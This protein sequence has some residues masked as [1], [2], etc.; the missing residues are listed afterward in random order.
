MK[1][2]IGYTIAALLAV[3]ILLGGC[4]KDGFKK[5]SANDSTLTVS[6]LTTGLYDYIAAD[7]SGNVYA[8]HLNYG[9]D[10]IYKFDA[11]G[12]KTLFYTAPT[13][14]DHDT[15]VKHTMACLSTDSL[16]NIYTINYSGGTYVPNVMKITSA[17]SA[18]TVYSNITPY[19]GLQIQKIAVDGNGYFYFSDGHGIHTIFT[20]GN[21]ELVVTGVSTFAVDKKGDIFYPTT[22]SSG[23]MSITETF[24]GG[25][26]SVIIAGP[27]STQTSVTFN[28]VSSLATDKYG[29]VFT[30]EVSGTNIATIHLLKYT[31]Y[32][33]QKTGWQSVNT[34]ISSPFG[35]VDGPVATAK[36][37]VP[38]SMTTD[39]N[40]SLYFS[41]VTGTPADIRNIS[42]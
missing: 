4:K 19:G 8:L 7:N 29:D 37:G 41:E 26:A 20:N 21:S 28:N 34:I 30:G 17:G 15:V 10:T 40:Q 33:P 25:G 13:T 14:T 23:Q 35:H 39:N 36:I 42:F 31:A 22:N 6:T 11:S 9:A 1:Q 5:L 32:N 3:T 24:T 12:N 38:F 27:G 18:S 2:K 16:G